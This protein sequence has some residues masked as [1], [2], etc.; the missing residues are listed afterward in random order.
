MSEHKPF[1]T[2][3]SLHNTTLNHFFR[4]GKEN[5]CPQIKSLAPFLQTLSFKA[6]DE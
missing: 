6:F 1:L 3:L 2:I 5:L 4:E